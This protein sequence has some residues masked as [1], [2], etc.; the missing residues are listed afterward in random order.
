MLVLDEAATR[1][2]LSIPTAIRLMRTAL[3]DFAQGRGQQ[4]MR[5]VLQPA[6][7]RG[8]ILIKPAVLAGDEIA[9]GLKVITV[10][11]DNP[12]RDLPSIAGFVALFDAET[13]VLVAILNGAVVTE[14][15]TAAVSAVATDVLAR[16]GD[17]YLAIIGAGVQA[18]A[19]LVAIASVRPL[20]QVTVWNRNASGGQAFVAWAAARGYGDL[21]ACGTVRE[22]VA[23]ADVICT[24][25]SSRE[26]LLDA[27]WI[28]AGAH[29]NAVGAFEPEARELH[30]NVVTNARV[31]VDSREEA[32]KAAG[33]LLIPIEEGKLKS[34]LDF[35]E[36][37][38]LLTGARE[39]RATAEEL[40]VFK[41]LGMALQDV[42]AAAY[43]V[44]VA[45]QRGLGIDVAL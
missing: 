9:V 17:V 19:H 18:R 45:R 23:G 38:E 30:T 11:P 16:P 12:Q 40:T 15:R 28:A 5:T 37:G 6:Q 22:A 10:F 36:L 8:S 26:P 13:G 7:L 33:D 41:S 3:Y 20:R 1:A 2:A 4:P 14:I 44:S 21:Q 24:V 35:P 34:V 31:V 27:N 42:A 29:I 25:T 32:A 39:G 43:V